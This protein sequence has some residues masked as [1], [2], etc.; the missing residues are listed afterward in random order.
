MS[1][2]SVLIEAPSG[3]GKTTLV[4]YLLQQ[5]LPPDVIPVCHVSMEESPQAAWRRFC[6]RLEQVDGQTGRALS[7]LGPPNED[8]VGEV[9]ALLREISPSERSWL[10]LDDFHLL[11]RVA[12]ISLWRAFLEHESELLTLFIVARPFEMDIVPHEKDEIFRLG[13]D[14]LR[15]TMQECR[16]YFAEAGVVIGVDEADD[17]HQRTEGAMIALSLNLRHWHEKGTFASASGIDALLRDLLWNRLDDEARDFLLQLSHFDCFSHE[18]AVGITGGGAAPV[19]SALSESMLL[20]FDADSGLYYPHSILLEFTRARFLELSKETQKTMLM[21]SGDWCAANGEREAAF[22]CYYRAGAFEKILALD[23]GFLRGMENGTLP[24]KHDVA[25]VDVLREIVANSTKEMKIRY[26][27]SLIQLAFAFFDQGSFEEFAALH[28]EMTALVETEVP[29][30]DRAY[31]KGELMLL[32]AFLDYNDTTLMAE[33]LYE[34]FLLTEGRT[35]VVGPGSSWTVGNASIAFMW[36]SKVG[37][38]DEKVSSM[39]IGIPY[40]SSMTGGHGSG[41]AELL[42]ADV[43]LLR[44]ETDLAKILGHSS[45]LNAALFTQASILL[46]VEFLFARIAIV[47]GDPAAFLGAQENMERLADE[48]PGRS[49]RFAKDM[50]FSHLA[51]VLGHQSQ[52]ARWIREG[53]IESF[54][55]RL[56]SRAVPF[57]HLCRSRYLLLA[58]KPETFLDESAA[59]MSPVGAQSHILVEIYYQIYRSAAWFMLGNTENALLSIRKALDLA[60]PDGVLLPF[61]ENHALI[62]EQLDLVSSAVP[63]ESQALILQLAQQIEAGSAVISDRLFAPGGRFV[64]SK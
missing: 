11:A 47:Q 7:A 3:Y 50:A 29:Q 1:V 34:S 22:G 16:E 49:V 26:P 28:A 46:A 45:L 61:A 53:S 27:L 32:Q 9:A 20:R 51:G 5:H 48:Y 56:F 54:G 59:V 36:H 14:D 58:G 17:L 57:A 39:A 8:S 25:H 44:G 42:E 31:L 62:R 12:P 15:L 4:Q 23:L 63:L 64:N 24:I 60:L 43:C 21:A 13:A 55:R 19:I 30:K 37:Y 52:M 6:Q 33:R 10:I 2:R 38:L 40:Y 35:A 41:G 18:Q